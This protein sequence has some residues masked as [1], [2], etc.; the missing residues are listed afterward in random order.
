MSRRLSG[1]RWPRIALM[2]LNLLKL[3]R[4]YISGAASTSHRL[5][6]P[7]RRRKKTPRRL[8]CTG[9]SKDALHVPSLRVGRLLAESGAS[10]SY[11]ATGG[12]CPKCEWKSKKF[13][14]DC[15]SLLPLRITR[16]IR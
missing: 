3:V 5:R 12:K 7:A 9:I 11:R 16:H 2:L 1:M 8:L 4:L 13:P 15:P 14:E 6:G 10:Q